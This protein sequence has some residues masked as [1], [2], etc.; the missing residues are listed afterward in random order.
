MAE[1]VRCDVA[2]GI[3]QLTLHNPPVNILTRAVLGEVR[4][5]LTALERETSLRVV[6]LQ[7]EGRHFSAGADVG[8][9][10][11][12]TFADLIP[13]FTATI[14]AL[15]EFPLPVIAAVRGRCLGGGF[16]LVQPAD[17]IIAGA[18]AQFGQP[19]ILLGVL[20]PAACALLPRLCGPARAATIVLGGD[21][22]TADEARACGLVM[23]VVSD[24]QVEA[25]ALALAARFARH[26][27]AALRA[28][29]RVLRQAADQPVSAGLATAERIY[30]EDLMQTR[31]AV[32][33]LEA[34]VA[35]RQP[36][37]VHG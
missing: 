2:D 5:H 28:T 8:E 33:G 31:D 16:E 10:L 14:R 37:W 35:K 18:G 25:A 7:A 11:P 34:F 3:A 6:V 27:G 30:V 15:W 24:D 26:S 13:E 4:T 32:E 9:H 12:P 20:P 23:D 21:S 19:E 22:L 17:A 1:M 29:K 36:S